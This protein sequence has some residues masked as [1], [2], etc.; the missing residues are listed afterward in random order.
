MPFT[1]RR[2]G[3]SC[4]PGRALDEADLVGCARCA[5]LAPR[6]RACG[7]P[8]GGPGVR[9]GRKLAPFLAH[10]RR[11]RRGAGCLGAG[12]CDKA[13]QRTGSWR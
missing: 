2:A 12:C 5:G 3:Q 6:S 13:W 7:S 4:V 1:G 9:R 10:R 8:S 11:V